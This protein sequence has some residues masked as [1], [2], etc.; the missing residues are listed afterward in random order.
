MKT[1]IAI[2]SRGRAKTGTFE[3][4][5]QFE[6]AYLFLEK[7]EYEDYDFPRKVAVGTE[8][9]G[10]LNA[11][12]AIKAFA[13]ENGYELV[14]YCDDDIVFGN[15]EAVQREV[16]LFFRRHDFVGAVYPS[17]AGIKW[18]GLYPQLRSCGF[19][20]PELI[21]ELDFVGFFADE[22][23]TVN[24]IHRGYYVVEYGLADIENTQ[25]QTEGIHLIEK[26]VEARNAEQQWINERVPQIVRMSRELRFL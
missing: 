6:D 7:D 26:D 10:L 5:R 8:R 19:V 3:W 16:D 25:I 13:V 20:Y 24:V 21:P 14:F 4:A 12:K 22:V 11:L 1:L 18:A 2:P 9:R 23:L 17:A 15:Y